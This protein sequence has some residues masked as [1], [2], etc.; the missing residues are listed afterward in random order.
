MGYSEDYMPTPEEANKVVNLGAQYWLDMLKKGQDLG[1]DRINTELVTSI[2][3][4]L[5]KHKYLSPKQ[6]R[7]LL[8]MEHSVQYR[9]D[10][11]L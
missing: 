1:I 8:I 4:H 3:N 9:M 11:Q 10:H 6:A 2:I 5:D 7:V